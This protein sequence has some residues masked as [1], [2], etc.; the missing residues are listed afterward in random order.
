V[1]APSPWHLLA[2]K[3]A[4]TLKLGGAVKGQL[5]EQWK[6]RQK[7]VCFLTP[8]AQTAQ[9]HYPTVKSSPPT[10][11][12]PGLCH[13]S[14]L[15]HRTAQKPHSGRFPR[16]MAPSIFCRETVCTAEL[17]KESLG[18]V[19]SLALPLP[20][21]W[22]QVPEAQALPSYCLL[23]GSDPW[24]WAIEPQATLSLIPEIKSLLRFVSLSGFVLFYFFLSSPVIFCFVS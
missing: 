6:A 22:L 4:W 1:Y 10:D 3:G 8:M 20:P 2:T 14:I 7:G 12:G 16:D 19:R 9:T 5:Q 21:S 15:G 24:A 23:L 11:A 17:S 18:E 13:G